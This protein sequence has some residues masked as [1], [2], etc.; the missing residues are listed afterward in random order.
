MR[1]DYSEYS[2]KIEKFKEAIYF[3]CD[4]N[5]GSN[6]LFPAFVNLWPENSGQNVSLSKKDLAI[7][8]SSILYGL[9]KR[10]DNDGFL[11]E[12]PKDEESHNPYALY[13]ILPHENLMKY[14][15]FIEKKMELIRLLNAPP[16][17]I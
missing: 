7:I 17:K 5:I 10:E 9:E 13:K 1:K 12:I 15:P 6:V 16:K 14:N 8:T 4:Y 11:F 3:Y 2:K